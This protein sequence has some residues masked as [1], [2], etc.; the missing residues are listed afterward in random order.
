M[1]LFLEEF[2]CQDEMKRVN[3][4]TEKEL[5]SDVGKL[6]ETMGFSHKSIKRIVKE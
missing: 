1:Q 5:D 3:E 2:F 6:A 4:K